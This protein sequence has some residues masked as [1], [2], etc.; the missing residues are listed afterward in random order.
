MGVSVTASRTIS[1]AVIR[2]GAIAIAVVFATLYYL[3]GPAVTPA[4]HAAAVTKC[5]EYASG[6]YR[7]F[8]LGWV[9]SYQ[10]HWT[11][12]DASRPTKPDVSFGWWV[13]PF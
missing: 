10:P 8:R 7:S 11:C 4:V 3:Y 9:V 6:N 13:N 5:N 1:A 2:R 12:W